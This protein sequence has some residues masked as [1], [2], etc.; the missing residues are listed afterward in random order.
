[1]ITYNGIELDYQ[2]DALNSLVIKGGLTKIDNLTDRTGTASTQFTL[3]RTAKNELAFGNITTEGA[4]VQ[5]NGEAYITIEGNIFSKG[6][7]YV[8][9]YDNDN[10]K[11]LFMG[12]D[13]DFIKT[14]RNKPLRTLFP[15]SQQFVFTNGNIE[16][17]IEAELGGSLGQDIKYHFGHPFAI[18]LSTDGIFD[19]YHVAP[20]FN[21]RFMLYKLFK[22]AGCDLVSNFLDSD[23]GNCLDYSSFNENKSSNTFVS[24]I[25]QMPFTGTANSIYIEL[26]TPLANNNSVTGSAYTG[27]GKKYT[28]ANAVT[29]LSIKGEIEFQEFTLERTSLNIIVYDSLNHL[30]YTSNTPLSNSGNLQQGINYLDF[31]IDRDFPANSY[32]L[33]QIRFNGGQ[34]V[35]P[36]PLQN[37]E[38][39]FSG[40]TITHDNIQQNDAIYFGDY[41]PKISQFEFLSGFIKHF[42]LVLD[43]EDDKAYL[44]LQD[45]GVEPIGASPASLPSIVVSQYD[46]TNLVLNETV[47]DIEYL[48]GDLI[49][50]KQKLLNATY[51]DTLSYFPYQAYGSYLYKLNTFNSSNVTEYESYFNCMYDGDTFFNS[52]IKGDYAETYDNL[53][54]GRVSG[55]ATPTYDGTRVLSYVEAIGAGGGT[56]NVD[57]LINWSEP[58]LLGEIWKGLYKKTLDQKKNNKI[59]EVIFRDELGTI[60]SNRREYIYKDQVYKIVEWSYD[61]IKKLVKAKLIMK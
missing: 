17:A 58:V 52:T 43:I 33:F 3:P 22:D 23:Y 16:T 46:I 59:I 47:T 28:L 48:Q 7:L 45:E 44:E 57:A 36:H 41:M 49:Y 25:N 30:L 5:T 56:V 21:I 10:F 32:I 31:N 55:F 42:N 20:F 54:T 24:T 38:L 6:V 8:T 15:A 29:N 19:P 9:G 50:L 40:T 37:A 26:G 14:L 53:I 27:G 12:Q 1:M 13:T 4:Q 39:I 2:S 51:P 18:A 35:I 61:I 34:G 11:C 60:V